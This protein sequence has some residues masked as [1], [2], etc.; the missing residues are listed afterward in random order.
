MCHVT[1]SIAKK[2]KHIEVALNYS[3][4]SYNAFQAYSCQKKQ[5]TYIL[6][7]KA[8]HQ[9]EGIRIT[10]DPTEIRPTEN[11]LCQEYLSKVGSPV[12]STLRILA[13]YDAKILPP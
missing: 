9:G 4:F 5:K 12:F 3:F 8:G 6:K 7:P 10:Q 2:H 11:V 13:S 1:N